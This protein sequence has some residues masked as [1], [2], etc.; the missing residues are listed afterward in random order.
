MPGKNPRG[1]FPLEL[2]QIDHTPLDL[3]LVDEENRESIGRAYLTLGIDVFSR[4]IMGFYISYEAPSFFN[5]GQCILNMI[6]PKDD[7]LK[8]EINNLFINKWQIRAKKAFEEK[9]TIQE[10]F[11]ILYLITKHRGYKSLDSDDL[12]EELREELGLNQE[13]KKIKKL[14]RN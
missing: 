10:F 5:T 7:F 13:V 9:L 12:F 4:M 6:M 14:K 11:S 3:D 2:V 8:Q 1:N